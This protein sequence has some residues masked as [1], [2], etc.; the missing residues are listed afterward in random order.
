MAINGK[1]TP[2]RNVVFVS[3]LEQGQ[4][5]SAGGIVIPDDN[6]KEHGI[7]ARWGKVFAVGPEVT[8]LKPGDWVLIKHGRWS[9]AIDVKDVDGAPSKIYRVDYPDAVELVS[10]E[11][12]ADIKPLN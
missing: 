7:R 2:L 12:P 3:E 6:G 5:I 1:I 9:F 11:F 10:D 8:D 4:R